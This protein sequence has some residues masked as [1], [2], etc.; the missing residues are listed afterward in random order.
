M[1]RARMTLQTNTLFTLRDDPSWDD[2]NRLVAF[3]IVVNTRCQ[4]V[5]C[6]FGPLIMGKSNNIQD[7]GWIL[8]I[9]TISVHLM[10]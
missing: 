8:F 9:E 6:N 1:T 7:V 4:Y 3:I 5:L 2:G 10:S